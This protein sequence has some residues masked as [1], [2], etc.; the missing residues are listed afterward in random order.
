MDHTLKTLQIKPAAT[1]A[2][3]T[4]QSLL[5]RLKASDV[6]VEESC[7]L[8]SHLVPFLTHKGLCLKEKLWAG[9]MAQWLRALTVLLKVLTSNPSNHMVAHNSP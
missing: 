3:V 2:P 1:P 4:L 5:L 6:R 9:A 8:S 7:L